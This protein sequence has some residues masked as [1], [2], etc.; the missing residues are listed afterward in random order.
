MDVLKYI[1]ESRTFVLTVKDGVSVNCTSGEGANIPVVRNSDGSYTVS[2]SGLASG[3]YYLDLSK[4][5]E[6]KRLTFNL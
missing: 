6:F 3:R 4:G 1:H 2:V 5:E